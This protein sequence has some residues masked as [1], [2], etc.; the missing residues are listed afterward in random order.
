[1]R[2]LSFMDN[3]AKSSY[4]DPNVAGYCGN[5]QHTIGISNTLLVAVQNM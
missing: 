2:D 5:D 4:M 3:L 1:M